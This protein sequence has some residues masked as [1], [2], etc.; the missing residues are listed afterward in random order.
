MPIIEEVGGVIVIK[1][2][3]KGA[4]GVNGDDS[5][6]PGPQGPQGD[7]G[8][9]GAQGPEGPAGADGDTQ[10][11][12]GK[13]NKQDDE[14]NGLSEAEVTHVIDG[15]GTALLNYLV[16]NGGGNS[17][18]A[19]SLGGPATLTITKGSDWP[20]GSH[21]DASLLVNVANLD[22][23]T[24]TDQAAFANVGVGLE[25]ESCLA[26]DGATTFFVVTIEQ[27]GGQLLYHERSIV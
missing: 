23:I 5:T 18:N 3:E 12:S 19:Y 25:Y 9:V 11:I 27:I 8:P 6:V 2:K 22:G 4:Q 7:T 10:D 20:V 16:A 26:H 14:Y 13:L 17:H 1:V 15:D 21:C 24:W